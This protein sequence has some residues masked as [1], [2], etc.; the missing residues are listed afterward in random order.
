MDASWTMHFVTE[1]CARYKVLTQSLD[2]FL[3]ELQ[4][5]TAWVAMAMPTYPE[6]VGGQPPWRLAKASDLGH[7]LRL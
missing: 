7:Q 2:T 3:L 5:G 4:D 6:T 1:Y